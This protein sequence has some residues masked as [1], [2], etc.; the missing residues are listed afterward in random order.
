MELEN[1]QCSYLT[2][3]FRRSVRMCFFQ[4]FPR[5]SPRFSFQFLAPFL[6]ADSFLPTA[7]FSVRPFVPFGFRPRFAFSCSAWTSHL[8]LRFR[9][10]PSLSPAP[11]F[12]RTSRSDRFISS[13]LTG[14]WLSLSLTACAFSIRP[15]SAFP[16]CFRFGSLLFA[17]PLPFPFGPFRFFAFSACPVLG[18]YTEISFIYA[19]IL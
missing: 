8:Q 9:W 2:A 18:T 3:G 13:A 14:T 19:V 16:L 10:L 1:F 17:F 4:F 12:T 15:F 11:V 7:A 5:V 6:P